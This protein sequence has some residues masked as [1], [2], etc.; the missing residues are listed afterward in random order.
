MKNNIYWLILPLIFGINLNCSSS[1]KAETKK[2][3]PS[4]ITYINHT[5]DDFDSVKESIE[6]AIEDQGLIVSGAL[7]I[8]EMLNRTGKDLG[9]EPIYKKAEGIEFCSS[10][11]S[12]LMAQ[13]DPSN[14]T[15]CPFTVVI[16][17]LTKE[18]SKTYLSFRHVTLRGDGKDIEKKITT[19]FQAIV[20][21]AL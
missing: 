21:E 19:L 12:H 10:K 7:H 2:T 9:F 14:I 13:V 4:P 6:M 20:D 8:S 15:M 18:P 17:Q 1:D 3:S 5:D 11:V 16:Y